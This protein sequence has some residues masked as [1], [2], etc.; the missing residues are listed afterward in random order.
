MCIRDRI[1]PESLEGMLI[2]RNGDLMRIFGDLR[3]VI[4][5]EIH[6]LTGTDRGNQIL[7]QLARLR[8]RTGV[9]PR[10][11]GLSATIGDMERA[12]DWL[13]AASGRNTTVAHVTPQKIR[14]RLGMEHF[15]IME[16]DVAEET[17][18][19]A[20]IEYAAAHPQDAGSDENGADASTENMPTLPLDLGYEL[21]LIHISEPTRP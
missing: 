16:K 21:S 7:C 15:F 5:D 3:Y 18:A 13:G 9:S 14:W 10:R 11:I 20:A 12:A 1:T 17:S 6:T 8:E 19:E 2:H 4:I